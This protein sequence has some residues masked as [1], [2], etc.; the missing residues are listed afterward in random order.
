M[1]YGYTYH[2]IA[3]TIK[4]TMNYYSI[5]VYVYIPLSGRDLVIR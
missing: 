1:L 3:E 4:W 5:L 2:K